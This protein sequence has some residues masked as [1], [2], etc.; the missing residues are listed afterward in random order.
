MGAVYVRNITLEDTGPSRDGNM[1]ASAHKYLSNPS[2]KRPL[3]AN[4]E[5][6]GVIEL[7]EKR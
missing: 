7:N 5:R 2:L 6:M 3:C 1:T 4:Y